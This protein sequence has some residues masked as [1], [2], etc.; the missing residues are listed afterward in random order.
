[1]A[2]NFELL[3]EKLDNKEELEN[4]IKINNHNILEEEINSKIT[5]VKQLLGYYNQTLVRSQ[6]LLTDSDFNEE[7]NI[8]NEISLSFGEIEKIK[9]SSMKLEKLNNI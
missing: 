2:Y 6:D 3:K 7:L 9:N 5:L 1:M 8:K 4:F